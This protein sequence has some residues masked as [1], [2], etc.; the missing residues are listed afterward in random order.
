MNKAKLQDILIKTGIEKL[1]VL[2]AGN[3]PENA[4]EL[5]SSQ[6]MGSLVQEMKHRYKNRYII[7]DSS[8]ILITA[9]HSKAE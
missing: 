1:V 4:S 8:P 9:E 3:S 6:R 2:P 7:F 5:L